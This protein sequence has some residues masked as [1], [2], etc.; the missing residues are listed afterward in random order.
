MTFQN[1]YQVEQR[2]QLNNLAFAKT[3]GITQSSNFKPLF[4]RGCLFSFRFVCLLEVLTLSSKNHG[5]NGSMYTTCSR[6]C[7]VFVE[8]VAERVGIPSSSC[9]LGN[10]PLSH[11]FRAFGLISSVK[12]GSTPTFN[13]QSLFQPEISCTISPYDLLTTRF[14]QSAKSSIA[15]LVWCFG[16]SGT[17]GTSSF[18]I[19]E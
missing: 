15:S 7:H 17:S 8:I 10:G 16:I 2:K 14:P 13:K 6:V 3:K 12:K 5:F 18:R 9:D 11:L 1:I 4:F 19:G